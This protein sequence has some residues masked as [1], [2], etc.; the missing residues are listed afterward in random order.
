MSHEPPLNLSDYEALAPAR[1]HPAVWDFISAGADDGVTMAENRRAFERIALWP[2]VLSD[3]SRIDTRAVVL[4]ADVSSPILIAP[5]GPHAALCPEG[6][7]A[8]VE[9]AGKAGLGMMA[10]CASNRTIEDIAAAA[11]GPLWLQLY[12]FPE[13]ERTLALVQRAEAAGCHALALTADSPRFGRKEQSL[14]TET[15]FDWPEPGNLK[16]LPPATKRAI[17]GAP[18]TWDDLGWLRDVTSLPIVLKGVLTAEDAA[19]ALA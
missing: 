3:V 2:R 8:T 1:M 17:R 18:A 16:G 6:E 15:E 13:R 12:L 10:N 9:A 11:T 19:M 4:G 5:T 7:V 14:R